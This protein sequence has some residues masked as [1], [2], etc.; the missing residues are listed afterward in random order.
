MTWAPRSDSIL[1]IPL[2]NPVPPPV[3]KAILP[4]KVP[5]GNIGVVIAGKYFARFETFAIPHDWHCN[6]IIIK[7]K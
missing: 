7:I 2:P 4:S 6:T 5:L 3:T 1:A